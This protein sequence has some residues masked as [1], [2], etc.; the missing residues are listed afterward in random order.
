MT[1]SLGPK[2]FGRRL[3]AASLGPGRGWFRILGIGLHWK[4]TTRHAPLFSERMGITGRCRIR[5]WMIGGLT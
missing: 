5:R 3:F 1:L 2:L 4:D